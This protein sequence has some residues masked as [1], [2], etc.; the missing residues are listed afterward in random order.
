MNVI[1]VTPEPFSTISGVPCLGSSLT[2]Y[3][4]RA[5]AWWGRSLNDNRNRKGWG[6]AL[7]GS[8][9][10]SVEPL[11]IVPSICGPLIRSSLGVG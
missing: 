2:S 11:Q 3:D 10:A 4:A 1:V 7:N 9:S 6:I 5:Q 8:I